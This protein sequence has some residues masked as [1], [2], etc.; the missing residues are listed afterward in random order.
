MLGSGVTTLADTLSQ[1]ELLIEYYDLPFRQVLFLEVLGFN[2]RY[3]D[4]AVY[5]ISEPLT[6]LRIRSLSAKR[7]C[8]GR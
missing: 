7:N 6:L 5:R 2:V 1:P 8:C 4:V 3:G